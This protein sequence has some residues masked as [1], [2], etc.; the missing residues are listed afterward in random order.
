ARNNH[1]NSTKSCLILTVE[2]SIEILHTDKM[3][4]VSQREIGMDTLDFASA[5][6]SA[7]RQDP[8]V[9]FVGEIRDPET[10]KAGLQA[11]ETG[12]LV[13]STLHTTNVTETVNRIIE[14]FPPYQQTQ[15][16]VSLARK[17]KGVGSQ[18]LV[19]TKA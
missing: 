11:A 3:A 7:M 14:F 13:I 1:I 18:R 12:H 10:V 8:D 17:L 5:L 15:I 9:I 6:R 4:I 19:P 2:A 16:R